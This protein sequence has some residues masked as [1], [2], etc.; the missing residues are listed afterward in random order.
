MRSRFSTAGHAAVAAVLAGGIVNFALVLGCWPTDWS[1]LYQALLACKIALV[2]AMTGLAVVNRYI[3][4]P[5][6]GQ[7]NG[8]AV[9]AVRT[10]AIAEILLGAAV[11]ALVATFGLLDPA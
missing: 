8:T 11:L 7:S 1:S 3:F 9:R 4:V 10:G 6:I 2:L 5:R